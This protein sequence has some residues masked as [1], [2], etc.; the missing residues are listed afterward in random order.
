MLRSAG[1]FFILRRLHGQK[2]SV[3]PN[4][5]ASPL[6]QEIVFPDPVMPGYPFPKSQL[7]EA[8]GQMEVDAGGILGEYPRLQGPEPR[9]LAVGDQHGEQCPAHTRPP[10][11][12]AD[13]DAHLGHSPVDASP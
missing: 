13:I 3:G 10:A 5:L 4:A 8:H 1:M 6:K 7:A 12:S 11:F 9:P 2:R